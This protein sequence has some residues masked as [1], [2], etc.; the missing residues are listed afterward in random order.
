MGRR[1]NEKSARSK[2]SKNHCEVI[3]RTHTPTERV[4][5]EETIF[6]VSLLL[7]EGISR[8]VFFL[9]KQMTRREGG[10]KRRN[11]SEFHWLST[12]APEWPRDSGQR[13]LRTRHVGFEVPARWRVGL[14]FEHSLGVHDE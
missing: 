2:A 6:S 4:G 7:G 13:F 14:H 1:I 10:R 11:I 12:P 5:E 8:E 3:E 9:Y